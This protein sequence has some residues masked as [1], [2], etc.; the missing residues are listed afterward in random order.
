MG[1]MMVLTE[2]VRKKAYELEK[3]KE[4]IVAVEEEIGVCKENIDKLIEI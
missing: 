3:Q 2:E 4:V 1:V